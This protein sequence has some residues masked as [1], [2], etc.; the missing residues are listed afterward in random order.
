MVVE[1]VGLADADNALAAGGIGLAIG[2]VDDGAAA[3]D[4]VLTGFVDEGSADRLGSS[5][6]NAVSGRLLI[7]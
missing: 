3:V 1:H 5:D 4:E 6:A 7:S 2:A